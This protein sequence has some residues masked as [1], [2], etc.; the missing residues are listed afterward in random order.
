MLD[1]GKKRSSCDLERIVLLQ[2]LGSQIKTYQTKSSNLNLVNQ[3]QSICLRMQNRSVQL[4]LNK[5]NFISL[6]IG[7]QYLF[8]WLMSYAVC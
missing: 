5:N 1:V 2:K 3:S 7:I 6:E 4:V 8:H